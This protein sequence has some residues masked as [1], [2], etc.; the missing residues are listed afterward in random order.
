[1]AAFAFVAC[2]QND[3]DAPNRKDQKAVSVVVPA[4]D[5][6]RAD[7]ATVDKKLT[8]LGYVKA[9]SEAKV[10]AKM[11]VMRSKKEEEEPTALYLYGLPENFNKMSEEEVNRTM[12]EALGSGKTVI[13]IKV[14][15][16]RN[17]KL[18]SMEEQAYFGQPKPHDLFVNISNQLYAKIPAGTLASDNYP[19]SEWEGLFSDDPDKEP[20]PVKDHA[21]LI[22]K[23]KEEL[24]MNVEEGALIAKSDDEMYVY[25]LNALIPDEAEK[26]IMIEKQG[27]AYSYYSA[28]IYE[29]SAFE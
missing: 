20:L 3:P 12:V 7:L 8:A 9:E 21:E 14:F 29:E 18:I 23:M 22:E 1:M 26:Q 27:V 19:Y 16:D 13:Q 6:I 15:A 24:S 10:P 25:S 17:N 2:N 4:F 5:W 11:N 28:W